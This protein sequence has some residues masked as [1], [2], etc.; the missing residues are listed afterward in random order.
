MFALQFCDEVM[1]HGHDVTALTS[2]AHEMRD[3]QH[4]R[5]FLLEIVHPVGEQSG[6]ATTTFSRQQQNRLV[7]WKRIYSE[8]QTGE[9]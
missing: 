9:M 4:A 7:S 8:K 6:L 3:Q 1:D 2:A 5:V